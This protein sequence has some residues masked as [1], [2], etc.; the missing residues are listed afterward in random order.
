MTFRRGCNWFSVVKACLLCFVA[1]VALSGCTTIS[2]KPS[3]SL[4]ESPRT[5]RAKVQIN[6]FTDQSPADDKDQKVAGVSCTAPGTLAGDLETEVTDAIL[7]DFNNNQVF[8]TVKKKIND[9][10]VILKG[11]I[12]RFQGAVSPNAAFWVTLPIDLIW[13]FGIPITSEEIMVDLTIEAYKKDG[14]LIGKYS[15]ISSFSDSLSMYN[16]PALAIP[17]HT[18]KCFSDAV[19]QIRDAM[20][21]DESKLTASK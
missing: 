19:K 1:A 21:L 13:F 7:T 18:N 10:D 17:S 3:V 15:G 4:S 16:N 12:N 20:L 14:S 2:Y 5:I 8:D 9:P 6:K 11:T